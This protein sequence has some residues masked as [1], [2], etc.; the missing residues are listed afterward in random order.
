MY[1]KQQVGNLFKK[2][3]DCQAFFKHASVYLVTAI[4]TA[5]TNKILISQSRQQNKSQGFSYGNTLYNNKKE[6]LA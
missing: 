6:R 5:T 2:K 4:A 1:I 3:M